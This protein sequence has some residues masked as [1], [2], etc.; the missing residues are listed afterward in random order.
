MFVIVE[1]LTGKR[2]NIE[3]EPS[4]TIENLKHKIQDKEGVP[5]EQQRLL[6]G[7]QLEDGCTLTD[8]G[9]P[10]GALMYMVIRLRGGGQLEQNIEET[11][12]IEVPYYSE[13]DFSEEDFS[14]ED[15]SEEDD[16]TGSKNPK[17]Q[18]MENL[19]FM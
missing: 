16:G 1:T 17:K 10:N 11:I 7:K 15:F 6:F 3:V 12:E 14:E 19:V 4:D 13:E 5:P 9:I 18:S 8:Y 2:L